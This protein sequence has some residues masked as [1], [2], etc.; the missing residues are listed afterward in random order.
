M[1]HR[2]TGRPRGRPPKLP[3]ELPEQ[4]MCDLESRMDKTTLLV[5]P[6]LGPLA[7]KLN[8]SRSSLKRIVVSLR[9]SGFIELCHV[10]KRPTDKIFTILYKL[11]RSHLFRLPRRLHRRVAV[12]ADAARGAPQTFP[13]HCQRF[14]RAS[15]RLLH[16]VDRTNPFRV[17]RVFRGLK[18]ALTRAP[19]AEEVV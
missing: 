12:K 18:L 17:F 15:R 9:N 14:R 1:K 13:P 5:A 8:I 16:S 6:Q 11:P 10:K 3:A 2:A 19:T 4:V 7:K